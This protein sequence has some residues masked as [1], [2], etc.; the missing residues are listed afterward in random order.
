MVCV[1]SGVVD[2]GL[3][4]K[5]F[6]SARTAL[7]DEVCDLARNLVGTVYFVE[8]FHGGGGHF[9]NSA[10]DKWFGKARIPRQLLEILWC[11]FIR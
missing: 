4:A 7:A 2:A 6:P 1:G 8:S 11:D 5:F 3:S 9:G 10:A